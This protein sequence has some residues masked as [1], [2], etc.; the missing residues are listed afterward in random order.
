MRHIAFELY[1]IWLYGGKIELEEPIGGTKVNFWPLVRAGL[2][3]LKDMKFCKALERN[4]GDT[5]EF[6]QIYGS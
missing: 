1:L 5:E 4:S 6:P 3:G 2:L